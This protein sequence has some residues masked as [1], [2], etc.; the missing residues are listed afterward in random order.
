MEK[1]TIKQLVKNEVSPY[2]IGLRNELK[3]TN[4]LLSTLELALEA[5]AVDGAESIALYGK[6]FTADDIESIKAHITAV[7]PSTIKEL[8]TKED[9][10]SFL[11]A[12]TPVYGKHYGTKKELKE[13]LKSVTPIKGVHYK[14]GVTPK[15]GLDYF[16]DK[17]IKQFLKLVTPV[18]GVHYKDGV[19]GK[20]IVKET[21]AKI[22]AEDI[23]NKLESLKGPARLSVKAIKG[24]SDLIL[25]HV[26]SYSGSSAQAG[27]GMGGAGSTTPTDVQSFE[28]L[29][30]NK[31]GYNSYMEYTTV[32]GNVTQVNYWHDS[33]KTKKLFTKDIAY[34]GSDPITVT[35][36][37]EVSGKTL[38]QTIAYALGE[39]INVTKSIA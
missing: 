16:T 22:S 26:K 6:N 25:E 13:M 28:L 5:L 12:V 9:L 11:K 29:M 39:I 7:V 36:R 2:L 38:T 3:T 34:S 1:K 33:T 37:D 8:Y 15:K 35:T 30:A 24:L 17:E 18:K 23:R 14:D 20:T 21:T 19:D 32:S 31:V 10:A 27:G 4:S